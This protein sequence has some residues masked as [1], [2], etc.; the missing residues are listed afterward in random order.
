MSHYE[1]IKNASY[2]TQ[3]AQLIAAYNPSLLNSFE[4]NAI[5]LDRTYASLSSHSKYRSISGF[6]NNLKHPFWGNSGTPVAR[7][8]PKNYADGVYALR[9]SVKGGSLPSARKISLNLLR[10]AEKGK[11]PKQQWSNLELMRLFYLTHDTAMIAPTES[12][13]RDKFIKCCQTGGT[14]FL[15]PLELNHECAPVDVAPDDPTYKV[16]NVICMHFLRSGITTAPDGLNA[17]EIRNRATS[18]FDHSVFYGD[19]DIQANSQRTYAGGKLKMD[20]AGIFPVDG[21]GV[22]AESSLR[23]I[24]VPIAGLFGVF[25]S[26]NHN[27]LA[28]NLALLNPQWDDETLFQEARRINIAIYQ[29]HIYS[30]ELLKLILG[31]TINENYNPSVDPATTSSF[32]TT[33]NRFGHFYIPDDIEFINATG[34]KWSLLNSDTF[35]TMALMQNNLDDLVRGMFRQPLNYEYGDD[36]SYVR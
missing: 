5:C 9:K 24:F 13:N 35:G 27:K 29:N 14:G 17:G 26:R 4:H 23:L 28:D 20:R 10:K 2:F 8:G 3:T 6:G 18:F 36:V 22:F 19:D 1:E 7:F 21:R 16:G 30:S 33:A 12:T 25:Y 15:S 32:Q 34:Y 31:E 11:R